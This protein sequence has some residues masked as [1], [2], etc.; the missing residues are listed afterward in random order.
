VAL[1]QERLSEP[2][3][4]G[5]GTSFVFEVNKTKIF[6]GGAVLLHN[7]KLCS[8]LISE[9]GSNW[10]PADN[11]FTRVTD[12]K[13]RHLLE[14]ARDGNQIM[15]RT[16]GGGIYEPDVFFDLCDGRFSPTFYPES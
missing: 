2:D 13:Y 4:Y 11:F 6:V 1:V 3:L 7:L 15:V 16:W 5:L 14:L 12:A 9:T 10:V 8:H